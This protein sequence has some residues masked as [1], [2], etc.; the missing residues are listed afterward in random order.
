MVK[1]CPVCGTYIRIDRDS[2]PRCQA[3][4]RLISEVKRIEPSEL[5]PNDVLT[6]FPSTS[7]RR[8]QKEILESVLQV[9]S[10]GRKCVILAA[11]TGFGKSYVNA[12]F[13]SLTHSFYATPQLALI[14]QIVN[15]PRLRS[16]LVEIKGRQNY[17]CY[18]PPQL[19]VNVIRD[20]EPP[21]PL[22][23]P[24]PM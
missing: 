18:H 15:D 12:A 20:N 11:P 8:Y 10:S 3:G 7:L 2:C 16:R 13:A 24:N 23:R 14:D 21:L 1:F 6:A 19:A 22:A 17:R 4:D 9:F 5:T